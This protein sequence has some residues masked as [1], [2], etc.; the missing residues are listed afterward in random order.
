MYRL[1]FDGVAVVDGVISLLLQSLLIYTKTI[2]KGITK[3]KNKCE[4]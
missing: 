1:S 4:K 2:N 3:N